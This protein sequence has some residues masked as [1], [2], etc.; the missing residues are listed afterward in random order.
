[1]VNKFGIKKHELFLGIT[2]LIIGGYLTF[3]SPD[4]YDTG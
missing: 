3:A 4:F 1:M 2:I